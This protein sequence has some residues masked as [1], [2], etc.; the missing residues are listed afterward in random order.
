M[1]LRRAVISGG[2][3]SI[4]IELISLLLKEGIEV[5]AFIRKNS[6]RVEKL[7]EHPLLKIVYCNLT[8]LVDYV[9][10]CY[11]GYDVF[12]HFAWDGTVGEARNDI[13]LQIKNVQYTIDAVLLA[14]RLGCHTFIG[15]GS[16]AEYGR[17]GDKLNASTPVFPENAYGI[18]KLCAGQMSRILCHQLGLKH[19]WTRIISVYGPYDNEKTMVMSSIIKLISGEIPKF[20]KGEQ[21]WDYLYSEDA[22]NAMYLLGEKG[23]DGKIY[24]LGSGEAKPL[25]EYIYEIRDI[26]N[27]NSDVKLGAIP[28]DKDQVMYLQADIKALKTDVGFTPSVEFSEGIRKIISL[29]SFKPHEDN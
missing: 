17:V 24:C 11:E 27:S 2:T 19:I 3:G 1:A 5:L 28:Y 12:Y 9:L 7:P 13:N 23:Y 4:G 21:M 14:K 15:A 8:E 26:I 10:Y 25:Y 16:Q 18:A 20:T 22:A 29:M 6:L